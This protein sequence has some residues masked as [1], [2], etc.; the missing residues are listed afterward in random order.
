M[1]LGNGFK[2][3]MLQDLCSDEDSLTFSLAYLFGA[4]D[5]RPKRLPTTMLRRLGA[6]ACLHQCIENGIG[7]TC[8][9]SAGRTSI[10]IITAWSMTTKI[11]R[12]GNVPREAREREI[13]ASIVSNPAHFSRL[14]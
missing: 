5:T 10:L 8:A 1:N 14:E 13:E 4:T 9:H 12:N 3:T 6:K 2:R 11:V 7:G